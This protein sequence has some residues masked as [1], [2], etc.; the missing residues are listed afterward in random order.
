[1]DSLHCM[2]T[3]SVFDLSRHDL[4]PLVHGLFSLH[5]FPEGLFPSEAQKHQTSTW[6]WL[7]R[8]SGGASFLTRNV[9]MDQSILFKDLPV[10]GLRL[11]SLTPAAETI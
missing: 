1:M 2:A 8:D 5:P 7:C 4:I 6:H 3:V 10:D 11:S 9:V